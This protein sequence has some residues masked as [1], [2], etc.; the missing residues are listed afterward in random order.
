MAS[1]SAMYKND[2]LSPTM[3]ESTSSTTTGDGANAYE[4]LEVESTCSTGELKASYKRL[5][6]KHHPDKGEEDGESFMRV[7]SA[8]KLVY[9]PEERRKYDMTPNSGVFGSSESLSL[10]DFQ[11][12]GNKLTKLCRC[13]D[14]YEVGK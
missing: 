9:C 11:I 3:C 12:D 7:Q 13:G 14:Y 6:L 4:I 2:V 1:L 10:R 5:L 8:W